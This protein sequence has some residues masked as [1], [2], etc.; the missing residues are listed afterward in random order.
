MSSGEKQSS[1]EF[2]ATLLLCLSADPT[3]VSFEFLPTI[4]SIINL[5]QNYLVQKSEGLT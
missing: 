2:S 5:I 3:K 1:R 4:L